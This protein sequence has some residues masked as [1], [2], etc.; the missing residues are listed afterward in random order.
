VLLASVDA[1]AQQDGQ[2]SAPPLDLAPSVAAQASANLDTSEGSAAG[3][4]VRDVGGDYLYIASWESVAWYGGGAAAAGLMHLADESLRQATQDPDATVTRALEAGGTGATYGNLGLQIPL[5]IGWWAFSH[6]VDS[7]RGASAS[8]DL[9][10]AQ[11]N[12]LS[13]TYVFKYAADRTRP[14]GDPR[15]FPSGHSSAVFATATVLEHYYGWKVGVPAMA[16]AAL[17]GASR[18]TVNK[19]WASD[20]V[21]GAFV[22]LAAGRTATRQDRRRQRTTTRLFAT[23]GGGGV[24][25]TW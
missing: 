16:A 20:V 15:S 22:G 24:T 5:A 21:F 11:I 1:R 17:T 8:R 14:N 18:V 9:V 4:F 6:A 2:R 10:R 19:H 12:A 23:P 3:R 7:A 25:V 13:W